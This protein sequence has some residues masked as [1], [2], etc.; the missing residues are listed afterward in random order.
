MEPHRGGR[1]A[2]GYYEELAAVHA[3]TATTVPVTDAIPDWAE[4]VVAARGRQ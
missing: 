3:G 1:R 2:A 4:R